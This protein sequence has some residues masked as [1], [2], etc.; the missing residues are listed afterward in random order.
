[1]FLHLEGLYNIS[2]LDLTPGSLQGKTASTRGTYQKDEG[3]LGNIF[4]LAMT[5]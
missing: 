2:R 1:M 5:S 3:L 4:W